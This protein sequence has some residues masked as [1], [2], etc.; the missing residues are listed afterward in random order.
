M[1][2]ITFVTGNNLKFQVASDIFSPYGIELIQEKIDVP[3]IQAETTEEVAC[4]SAKFAANKLNKPVIVN[5]SGFYINALNGF[6]GVYTKDINKKFNSKNLLDL[7]ADYDDRSVR[8][9]DVTAFCLP[10]NEPVCFSCNLKGELLQES[11][12]NYPQ[13]F[14]EIM[15]VEDTGKVRGQYTFEELRTIIYPKLTD[16]HEMAKFL[17]KI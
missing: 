2:Q 3:E 11:Q 8:I 10:N 7:M 13:C 4:F 6:P 15:V 17:L 12:G 1:T 16:Y 5:D 9:S 14:D